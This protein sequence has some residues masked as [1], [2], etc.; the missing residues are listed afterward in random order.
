[1][2]IYDV[3]HHER[4]HFTNGKPNGRV[5][6]LK[7]YRTVRELARYSTKHEKVFPKVEAKEKG[8]LKKLLRSFGFN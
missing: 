2:N 7:R 8:A 4:M 5:P 3:L 6:L 1:M